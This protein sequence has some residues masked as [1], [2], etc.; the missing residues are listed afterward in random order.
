MHS[1][2]T[3]TTALL[4][5]GGLLLA[6]CSSSTGSST[7]NPASATNTNTPTIPAVFPTGSAPADSVSF[8]PVLIA[9]PG[10]SGPGG[11]PDLPTIDQLGP[12]ALDG[13]GIVRA[14]ASPDPSTDG[15][16]VA[17][18]L[19]NGPAGIDAFNA[20]AAA[21]FD[22][23]AACPSGQFAIVVDGTVAVAPTVTEPSY[24]ADQIVIG[25]NWTLAQAED[26]ARQI[27]AAA[28]G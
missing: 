16:R 28:H 7:Q 21:C 3:T 13:N 23:T 27:S 19:A 12:V 6:A 14:T 11:A 25:G 4:L 5:A 26:I 20:I 9:S 18:L 24:Q 10:P 1:T 15:G 8:R 17:P 22:R 2:R